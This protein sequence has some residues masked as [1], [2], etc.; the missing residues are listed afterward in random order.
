[1]EYTYKIWYVA[2]SDLYHYEIR[3]GARL[4]GSGITHSLAE[5]QEQAE[6]RIRLLVA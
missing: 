3:S 4:I 5:S 1:M 6:T 2:H